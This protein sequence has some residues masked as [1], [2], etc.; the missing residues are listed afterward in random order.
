M[1]RTV[2]PAVRAQARCGYAKRGHAGAKAAPVKLSLRGTMIEELDLSGFDTAKVV[3]MG[4]ADE[5]VKLEAI[6]RSR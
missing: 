2:D 3:T 1:R 4:G 5:E 6:G